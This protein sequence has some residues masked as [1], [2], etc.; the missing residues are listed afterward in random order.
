MAPGE[1]T[2]RISE[3]EDLG[4]F[5][6]SLSATTAELNRRYPPPWYLSFFVQIIVCLRILTGSWFLSDPSQDLPQPVL[7]ILRILFG[8]MIGDFLTF[9]RYFYAMI[10]IDI[11]TMVFLFA[12][13]VS[14][15]RRRDH[16]A[17]SMIF[18]RH[19]NAAL[20]RAFSFRTRS[21]ASCRSRST[22]RGATR[23]AS[24]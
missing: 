8:G 16:R 10:T 4:A 7:V 9:E 11:V 22:G 15:M 6:T 20:F 17:W 18:L 12:V 21:W 19:W 13:L 14:Y 24:L 2:A 1:S 5:A 23:A 3:S